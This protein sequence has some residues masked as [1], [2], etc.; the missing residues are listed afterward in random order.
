MPE[1]VIDFNKKFLYTGTNPENIIS[2]KKGSWFF[3]Y[4]KDFYLNSTGDWNDSWEK[5]PY[6][7]VILPA[8]DED[9][10]VQYEQP[11]ELWFKEIDGFKDE[12]RELLPKTGWKLFGYINVFVEAAR[13]GFNWITPPPSSSYDSIGKNGNRS[14][15]ENFYY[16]KDQ[17]TWYRTPITIFDYTATDSGEHTGSYYNLPYVVPP[18]FLP[19]PHNSNDQ[20]QAQ[21]GNESYDD[22]FYYIKP[23]KWKRSTMIIFTPSKMTLF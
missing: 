15:D 20:L 18:R 17:T 4:N 6:R 11:Y 16:F 10:I 13:K 19:V 7:T 9:W 8:V 12:H 23:S 3:R 21:N 14:Y 5:L 22:E 1:R 2:A